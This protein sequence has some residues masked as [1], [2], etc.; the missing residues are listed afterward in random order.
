MQNTV[1]HFD[2]DGRFSQNNK[3]WAKGIVAENEW[4]NNDLILSSHPA[5]LDGFTNQAR[6]YINVLQGKRKKKH[7]KESRLMDMSVFWLMSGAV[8]KGNT[9]LEMT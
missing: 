2:Y 9:C 5:V 7:S 1:T 8:K 4:E 3:D 6:R